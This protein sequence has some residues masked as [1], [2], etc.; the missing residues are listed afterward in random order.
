MLVSAVRG[1]SVASA[2]SAALACSPGM[3]DANHGSFRPV[4]KVAWLGSALHGVFGEVN[5]VRG[6]SVLDPGTASSAE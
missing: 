5:A 3:P 2:R 6:A 1:V 4:A